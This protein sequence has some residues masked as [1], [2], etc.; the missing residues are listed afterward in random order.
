M[1]SRSL[2]APS[3]PEKKEKE[4]GGHDSYGGRD[5]NH[6]PSH[7]APAYGCVPSPSL[8]HCRDKTGEEKKSKIKKEV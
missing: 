5:A 8:C 6:N 3:T 4:G 7:T 2:L 1:Y